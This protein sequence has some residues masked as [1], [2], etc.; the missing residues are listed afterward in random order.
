MVLRRILILVLL[1]VVGTSF[2]S[3]KNKAK[4][5]RDS[6]KNLRFSILGGPGYTPDFGILIG[7]SALFTFQMNMQDTI[8]KRS[9]VPVAFAFLFEGGVNLLVRPQ[10]FFKEDKIRLM[11]K[12]TYVNTTDNYYGIGYSENK[13]ITRSDSTTSYSNSMFQINPIVLFRIPSSDFFVGP[14]YDL[15][16]NKIT[17]PSKGVQEDPY[18]VADGGESEGID[19][20]TSGLGFKVSYD[21]RDVPAN[22]YRGIYFDLQ[23]LQYATI[24]GSDYT[25]NVT[26]FTYSQYLRLPRLGERSVLAWM[27]KS[28]YASGD[29]PFTQYPSVGSPFDLRGYYKGQFRDK[30]A[31]AIICEYRHMLNIEPHNFATKMLSKLG[32]AAWGGVGFMGPSPWDIDGVLPNYGVGLR[33]EVQP[34]MNFRM[35]IGRDPIVGNTLLYFNMTE[36]F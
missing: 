14:V 27:A 25:F 33:I 29:I 8:S 9:V 6:T 17:D 7:G 1:C 32:F 19:M 4:A 5:E 3:E 20:L 2:A 21:T 34:R 24:F 30:S 36:A 22:A 23:F 13:S 16:I 31:S 35:D 15:R 10:L 28:S 26:D 12:Y 11:G 18:Y